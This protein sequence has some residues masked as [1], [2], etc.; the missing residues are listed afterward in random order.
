VWPDLQIDWAFWNANAQVNQNISNWTTAEWK[1]WVLWYVEYYNAFEAYLTANCSN[2]QLMTN[3]SSSASSL[4]GSNSS[5][6]VNSSNM[7]SSANSS[8]QSNASCIG[9]VGDGV[10]ISGNTNTS[11]N[12]SAIWSPAY[13]LAGITVNEVL[14]DLNSSS[15]IVAQTINFF[16]TFF[17]PNGFVTMN[18][19]YSMENQ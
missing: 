2:I 1:L 16:D 14:A 11:L 10:T 12:F 15:S 6:G 8:M 4:P 19:T 13:D 17:G 9:A 5:T 3:T 18:T 7:S